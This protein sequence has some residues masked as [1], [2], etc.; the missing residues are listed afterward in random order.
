MP[1]L[2]LQVL[3]NAVHGVDGPLLLAFKQ[4]LCEAITLVHRLHLLPGLGTLPVEATAKELLLLSLELTHQVVS[5]LRCAFLYEYRHLLW[6]IPHNQ[7]I[8]V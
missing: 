8:L 2:T 1:D 5:V 4:L 7:V 3:L 6:L